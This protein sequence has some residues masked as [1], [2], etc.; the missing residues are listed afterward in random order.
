MY[1]P[2]FETQEGREKTREVEIQ[3][4]LKGMEEVK[5][6]GLLRMPSQG[7]KHLEFLYLNSD[8]K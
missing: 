5:T 4:K 1:I 8:V 7:T 3:R 2:R 6:K